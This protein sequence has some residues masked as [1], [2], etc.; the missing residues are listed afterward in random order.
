VDEGKALVQ[1]CINEVAVRF[2]IS[3]PKWQMCIVTADGITEEIVSPVVDLSD[4]VPAGALGSVKAPGSMA[5]AAAG[6]A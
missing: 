4:K 1:R 5:G 3:Q 2:L 6:D